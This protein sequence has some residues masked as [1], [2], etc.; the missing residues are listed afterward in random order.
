[1][2]AVDHEHLVARGGAGLRGERAP[3]EE[4]DLEAR[5]VVDEGAVGADDRGRTLRGA[6]QEVLVAADVGGHDLLDGN[7]GERGELLAGEERHR[8]HAVGEGYSRVRVVEPAGL[9][10]DE[11]VLPLFRDDLRRPDH[12]A[13][14]IVASEDG[15]DD[16]VVGPHVLEAAEHPGRDVEEVALFQ[17]HFAGRPPP[18]P[19]EPPA[20]PPSLPTCP[21]HWRPVE[22]V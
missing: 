9:G 1:M 3:G 14:R 15:H 11:S 12:P 17:D 8:V 13:S 2:A 6:G 18:P 22:L 10:E 7:L 16:P 19:E 21:R 4:V 5:P 20:A